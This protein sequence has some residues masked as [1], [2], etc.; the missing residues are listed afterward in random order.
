MTGTHHV[1]CTRRRRN[2]PQRERMNARLW[3]QNCDEGGDDAKYTERC[4]VIVS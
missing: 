4:G 3:F 2:G 1:T